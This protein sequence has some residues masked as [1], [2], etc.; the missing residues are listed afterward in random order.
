M[1]AK[2][3]SKIIPVQLVSF[4][5]V[6]YGTLT[7]LKTIYVCLMK[8][9]DKYAFSI[10]FEGARVR[11]PWRNSFDYRDID[12]VIRRI[13]KDLATFSDSIEQNIVETATILWRFRSIH[14]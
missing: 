8:R 5:K 9:D 10:E 2:P 3:D 13:V 11:A 7:D 12:T 6:L 14:E 4:S 1:M